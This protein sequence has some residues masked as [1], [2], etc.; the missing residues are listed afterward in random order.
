MSEATLAVCDLLNSRGIDFNYVEHKAVFTIEDMLGL[1]LPEFDAV[2]KNLFVRDDKKRN[3]Y[4]IVVR[5]EKK[6]ELKAFS[7]KIGSSKL[8]FA[9]ENDLGAI[10]GLQKGAV[11]PFGVL[12]DAEHRVRVLIDKSFDGSRIGIHPNDNTASVWLYTAD[13]VE[14][15][16]QHGNRVEF[17]EL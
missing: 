1:D 5:H 3:Y 16:K 17:I 13:L 14:V 11:T 7:E 2:A 15:I 8:S 9:S 4:L 6:V 10:L 12:N